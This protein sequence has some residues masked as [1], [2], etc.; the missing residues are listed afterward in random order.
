M[1][2][3]ISRLFKNITMNYEIDDYDDIRKLADYFE[4][5]VEW[6]KSKETIEVMK[7]NKFPVIIVVHHLYNEIKVSDGYE[8]TKDI[9]HF[10]Q[11]YASNSIEDLEYM[12]DFWEK[13][14]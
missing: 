8:F 14:I 2:N 6:N 11:D 10:L 12:L 4:K 3:R 13:I 7:S 1:P 9:K 5:W